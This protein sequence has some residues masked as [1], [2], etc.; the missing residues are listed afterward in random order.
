V[1]APVTAG[2]HLPPPHPSS[3][4]AA[5]IFSRLRPET[6]MPLLAPDAAALDVWFD[7]GARDVR[8]HGCVRFALDGPWL[9]GCAE[10]DDAALDG[11]LQ[12][13]ARRVYADLFEV[14]AAH[15]QAQLLRLWN[16]FAR[17]N[18]DDGG[19]ERYR[20]FNIGR[21]QAF[22]EARHSAFE[23]AP[24]ACA[25]GTR[26]GPLRVYFLAGRTAP[27]AIENPRQVSAYRYPDAYGPRSPSFSRAALADIGG[28]RTAFFISGTASIVGHASMHIGD[29]RRQAEESLSNIAALRAIAGARAGVPFDAGALSY[30]I[31]LRRPADLAAVREVFEREVGPHSAAARDAVYLQADICRAEL[32][33]ELEAHGFAHTGGGA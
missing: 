9:Y 18:A 13:A 3:V 17:I 30:T 23:G 6:G 2:A 7:A 5:P 26:S 15:D 31:Y 20:Q 22:I 28:G 4:H 24:A 32:L 33:V 25:L 27:L 12:A 11:G 21:Q 29:V 10:L 8:R 19:T 14:L 16:Y 1:I